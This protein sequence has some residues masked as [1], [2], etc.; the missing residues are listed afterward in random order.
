MA[1]GSRVVMSSPPT[2][3]LDVEDVALE[4]DD[5][6]DWRVD[7]MSSVAKWA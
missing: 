5:R 4:E 3:G 6:V 1:F 7:L 2:P